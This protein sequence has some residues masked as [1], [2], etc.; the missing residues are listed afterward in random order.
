MRQRDAARIKAAGLAAAVLTL[1]GIGCVAVT[2]FAASTARKTRICTD[3]ISGPKTASQLGDWV[4]NL[5]KGHVGCLHAGTYGSSGESIYVNPSVAPRSAADGV[6]VR[7]FPHESLPRIIGGIYFSGSSDYYTFRFLRVDG[8][9]FDD[10]T[11]GIAPG[12]YRV[13]LAD[14]DITNR[15]RLGVHGCITSGGT[16]LVI[17]RSLIHGCG[18]RSNLG[19]CVYLGHGHPAIVA[20]NVIFGC[21]AAAIHMYTNPD[22][23]Y[24]HGNVLDSSG[25]GV[26]FAGG[27]YNG[28]CEA[29]D[30]AKVQDNAITNSNAG[31]TGDPAAESYW[32]C[33]L[34][35]TGNVFRRNCMWRNRAGD[36]DFSAGGVSASGNKDANPR[37]R[38]GHHIPRSSRCR[39]LVGDPASGLLIGRHR[40]RHIRRR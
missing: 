12:A 16:R 13:T 38:A 19:H 40:G 2:T 1:V 10:D 32:G 39:A 3:E 7:G 37:Y 8:S 4:S 34:K 15:N 21:G 35:G 17:K 6:K 36:L 20:G 23:A 14:L 9:S 24:V 5:R 22:F 26:I 33:G 29:T 18:G 11:V 27:D 30:S 25:H 28:N 31:T